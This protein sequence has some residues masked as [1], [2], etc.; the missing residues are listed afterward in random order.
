MDRND[1][2]ILNR[3]TTWPPRRELS[4]P[5]VYFVESPRCRAIKIGHTEQPGD[6]RI[7]GWHTVIPGGVVVLAVVRGEYR[8]EQA[9]HA[10]FEHTHINGEWYEDTLELRDAI[11][12]AQLAGRAIP[13]G[14]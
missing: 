9:Y 5:R 11:K 10:Q 4:R 8:D 13:T 7:T 3:L 6:D 14:R 12:K 1:P 2:G